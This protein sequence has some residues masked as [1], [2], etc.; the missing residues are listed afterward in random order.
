MWKPFAFCWAT[1]GLCISLQGCVRACVPALISAYARLRACVCGGGVW[2]GGKVGRKGGTEAWAVGGG[3]AGKEQPFQVVLLT[4]APPA[5]PNS[6]VTATKGASA[7]PPLAAPVASAWPSTQEDAGQAAIPRPLPAGPPCAG[8][9]SQPPILPWCGPPETARGSGCRC[10]LENSI[11]VGFAPALCLFG[12][13]VPADF[14]SVCAGFGVSGTVQ[15]AVRCGGTGGGPCRR[16]LHFG[17]QGLSAV[18]M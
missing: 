9:V 11:E 13:T 15:L 2:V 7:A 8:K 6:A 12:M 10:P 4:E 18:D 3:V 17:T 1:L 14:L 16:I 5:A